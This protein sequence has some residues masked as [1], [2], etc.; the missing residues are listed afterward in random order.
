MTSDN[1][2][3]FKGNHIKLSVDKGDL[4]IAAATDLAKQKVK[5]LSDDSMMLSWC[6]GKTGEY[7]PKTECGRTEKPPWIIFAESRG[8]DIAI[9]I[10]DGEYIFLFLSL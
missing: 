1:L 9:N 8:A 4:G 2:I 5:E 7:Y 3:G 10:N 6:C